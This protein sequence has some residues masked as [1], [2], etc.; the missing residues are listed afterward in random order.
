MN[1]KRHKKILR[2]I[3]ALLILGMVVGLVNM[4]PQKAR[5]AGDAYFTLSPSSGSYSNG[6]TFTVNIYETSTSG[7]QVAGVQANLTYNTTYLQCHSATGNSAAWSYVAQQTCSGG[8][9]EIG[10]AMTT[11]GPV[12]S[13]Q[14][15]VGTV[16]FTVIGLSATSSSGSANV[17][18]ISGGINGGQATD[19]ENLVP[20][21]AWN[22]ATPTA[23]FALSGPAPAAPP[24]PTTTG[25]GSSGSGSSG[26]SSKSDKSSG[27][28][29]TTST[30]KTPA[31]TIPSKVSAIA[32]SSTSVTVSWDAST[33]SGGP[34]LGG[35]YILRGGTRIVSINASTTSY[36]D[37]GLSP[38]TAYSYTVEAYDKA[39]PPNV[40]AV[41]SAATVTTPKST[42]K[43]VTASLTITVT[44]AS[45]KP[46]ANAKVVLN[47][48]YS[49]YTNAQG[50]AGF[51]GLPVGKYTASVQ[52]NDA[53]PYSTPVTLDPGKTTSVAVKLTSSSSSFVAIYVA[54]AA[55]LVVLGGSG[56]WYVHVFRSGIHVSGPP[57]PGMPSPTIGTNS[58]PPMTRPLAGAPPASTRPINELPKPTIVSP[59]SSVTPTPSTTQTKPTDNVVPH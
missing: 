33:D 59:G 37:T 3:S 35:Y 29:S 1:M 19:I 55:V 49:E 25:S 39:S 43:S 32:N 47:G 53:K 8:N 57:P 50:M 15:L 6:A 16:S 22:D 21:T 26:S 51:S 46:V 24:P 11:G 18:L 40:S 52:A 31:P 23:T 7:D 44:N 56:Y 9:I 30:S 10:E 13:G 48:G 42:A 41:S 28:G 58:A 54:A 36:T 38:S 17:G 20:A 45:G 5:A 12:A 34:G 2:G 14:Q 27:T 4:H